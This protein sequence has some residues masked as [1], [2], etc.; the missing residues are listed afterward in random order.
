MTDLPFKDKM[1]DRRVVTLLLAGLVVLFGALYAAAA[2]FTGDKV[3]RGTTVSGVDIGGLTPAAAQATLEEELSP[4]AE[5]PIVV[6][7]DGKRAKIRPAQAGLAVDYEESVTQAG[8]GASLHPG[9]MW[10]YLAG[11]DDLEA[12]VTVDE[13]KL[14]AAIEK[15]AKQ[16]DTPAVEGNVT[17]RNGSAQARM[18]KIGK[19]LDRDEAADAILGSYLADNSE[20]VVPLEVGEV[21]PEVSEKDVR[22]AMDEFANP[23]MSAPVILVL[24]NED[25]VVRPEAFSRALS[26]KAKD[27]DLVPH[28]DQKKLRKA[29]EVAMQSGSLSP[30][31]ATVRLVDGQPEVIPGKNGVTFSPKKVAD[32]FASLVVQRGAKR[33][34]EV[35]TVVDEPDFTTEDAREL[36]IKEV[37]SSF[38]TSFPHSDYRNVNLGR[39]ADLVNGTVLKPGETFSLNGTVGER[40]AENGFTKGYI[41]SNGVYKEDF[42]G[43]VSQVATTLFNAA[44]FAGLEDVEH[45]P[46]SFYIDRYPIGREATV[47]WGALDLKFKNDTPYGVLVESWVN[48]STS[49]SSG[50]MNVRLWSTKYWDITA[51][52]SDRYDITKEETRYIQGPNC[53]PHEGYGGFDIDVFRYFRRAGSDELVRKET[54]HTTYTPSDTV[55]CGKPPKNQQES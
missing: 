20:G 24:D 29:I 4:L 13:S 9:R 49:S 48:P 15:F 32:K 18:P 45:K 46:H 6:A 36:Q 42:G 50:T 3:P 40:T 10:D 51:G 30:E 52:V 38:T 23:A 11:G 53:V 26:M 12:V 43:G 33:T 47:V 8:A 37:V 34:H 55:V 27:G 1:T 2:A 7:A 25:V 44:F 5:D 41:I 54:M 35:E 28:V 39:A 22:A 19:Q 16:V 17:F 21:E 31:P 14:D